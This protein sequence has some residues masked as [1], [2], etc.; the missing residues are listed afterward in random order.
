[1]EDSLSDFLF[2]WTTSST[3]YPEIAF[4]L[5]E[6]TFVARMGVVSGARGV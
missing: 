5:F 3:H 6:A 2:T 4:S 1:M